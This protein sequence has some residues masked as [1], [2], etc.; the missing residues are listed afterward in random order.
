[1]A[2]KRWKLDPE[3][4]WREQLKVGDLVAVVTQRPGVNQRHTRRVTKVNKT[5]IYVESTRYS[6]ATGREMITY[7]G[8][9][10]AKPTAEED[11]AGAR[12]L[13]LHHVQSALVTAEMA[14]VKRVARVLGIET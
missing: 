8:S 13:L 5:Y 10:I 7:R 9:R 2:S 4:S 14:L 12:A 1:M 11:R 3:R 6:P